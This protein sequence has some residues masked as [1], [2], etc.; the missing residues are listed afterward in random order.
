MND[1][2]DTPEMYLR[3]V[4]EL[5]EEEIE[6]LRAR[7][8]ER[9]H[10]SEPTVSQTVGRLERDGLLKVRGDR[11]IELS[12]EGWELARKVMRKHRLAERLLS[13]IIGLD[14]VMV[15]PEACKLE[16][17]FSDAIEE[18]LTVLLDSP[19]YSTYG[20][21]IPPREGP[22]RPELFREGLACLAECVSDKPAQFELV[23][24]TECVQADDMA[25][26]GLKDVG[27]VPGE[28]ISALEVGSAVE[29]RGSEGR[30][31]VDRSVAAGLWVKA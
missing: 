7:I 30:V 24:I 26:P 19:E 15:H 29:L 3:T 12:D 4:Y 10:Q 20:C 27:V 21:P 5:H 22:P 2:I 18:R 6:P 1:L 8:V 16:H 14:Y 31:R 9:L 28:N 11:Q 23:R 13:D 25:L 17:V